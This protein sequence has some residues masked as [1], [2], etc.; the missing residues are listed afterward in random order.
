[1][2]SALPRNL[3]LDFK[4]V[5]TM[6]RQYCRA[7]HAEP[8]SVLCTACAALTS[9]AEMRLSKCPFSTEKT[10]CRD[11]PVHCYRAGERETMRAVMVFAG[12]RML[13]THP[14]LA[15]RHLWLERRGAPPWPPRP[16][17]R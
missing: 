11:C 8:S 6:V 1:M 14:L 17:A 12:P 7:K 13:F 4:T 2:P 10:T 5:S 9:Y 16:R 3:A 15:I